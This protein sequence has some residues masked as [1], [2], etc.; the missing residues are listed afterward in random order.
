MTHQDV[1]SELATLRA[2]VAELE[3]QLAKKWQ[4]VGDEKEIECN[5]PKRCGAVIWTTWGMITVI[6]D[7]N[8]MV[9]IELPD[10]VRLCRQVTQL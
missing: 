3:A 9:T 5:C 6:D 7:D 1:F 2:H 8:S 4:P 10:N